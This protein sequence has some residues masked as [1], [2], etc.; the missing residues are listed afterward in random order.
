MYFDGYGYHGT[1]FE[2]TY[3]CYPASFIEKP[4]LESGDK[5]IM[6]P[7]ALDRLASLHIDYPMLFELRNDAAERVSH[8]G[9]LEFI[10]EEG[11]IYM[12]YWMMENMLLQEGDV[13]RVKNVTLPKGKYVKLQPHTKDFLD[14]SNPKAI[15]ETTLRNFSCLTTGDSIMVA[16]N[17]KKYYIDIIETKPANAISIIETDCEVDFAP[18]LDYKEPEKPLAPNL[19]NKGPAKV[20]EDPAE[21]EPKF[22]PF[23]GAGRRLDGKPLKLDPSPISSLGSKDKRHIPNGNSQPSAASSS[24]SS[25]HQ[26]Q[27]K[28]VF[29]SNANRTKETTKEAV[30]ESKQESQKE[31]PKF[32]PF[33]GKKYSLRG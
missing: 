17:N 7:S 11:M 4:Q 14:I 24:Q 5:I 19:S 26:S 9:V 33:T 1:S 28:L 30:K 10:A 6:P 20:E 22:N 21:A 18:P 29:G 3:R 13:V 31:E 27:G 12:P 8:C 25:G 23:S 15:L 2:Q 16:Y 32:Q